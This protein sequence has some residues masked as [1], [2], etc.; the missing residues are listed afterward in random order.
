M[1][2][3]SILYTKYGSPFSDF[4]TLR[5]SFNLS[6]SSV[7]NITFIV[8]LSNDISPMAIVSSPSETAFKG[9]S[10]LIFF[11]NPSLTLGLL[12]NWF[13][14]SSCIFLCSTSSAFKYAIALSLPPSASAL[15]AF[16]IAL[17][18]PLLPFPDSVALIS[19][20][21][22]CCI[23]CGKISFAPATNLERSFLEYS[24]GSVAVPLNSGSQLFTMS[25]SPEFK[26]FI[27]LSF[28]S[29]TSSSISS[30]LDFLIF[31]YISVEKPL[32]FL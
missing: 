18:L 13:M 29:D 11:I 30:P 6:K 4:F 26:K 28:F 21:N 19:D 16:N 2:K 27:F 20:S 22:F 10:S 17:D 5:F 9:N 7:P 1:P 15:I 8:S 12:F 31:K 14:A 3:S 25:P 23:D 32:F 24:L